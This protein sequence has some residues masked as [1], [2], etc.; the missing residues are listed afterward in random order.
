MNKVKKKSHAKEYAWGYVMIAPLVI[1]LSVFYFYPVFKV[2]FDSFHDVGAF[3]KSKWC[4]L[5]N[6]Q[7]MFQDPVMWQAL[8]NTIKYVLIIVPFTIIIALILASFLNMGIKGRSFFRVV[9]FIPAITMG[10]AVAMIW[11]WMYNGDYGIINY[12]L[13]LFG[14]ESI[15]FLSNS[16]TALVSI[17][18]VSIWSTVGYNMIILLAG[19][20]GISKSYYEAAAIDGAN[21]IKQ[22]LNITLPLVTPTLFFVMITTL[23]S[24]FQ[25]FDTIYMMVDKTS[26]AMEST[27]SMV[28][29]FY[30]NAFEYSKKGYASALAV[31]LFAIIMVI[32]AFQMKMQ[33]KWVNYE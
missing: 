11:R 25:T 16:K 5:E 26:L 14:I 8:G 10:A 15:R 13:N 24:T 31:F 29:Y 3:N 1:G 12:I 33:T 9:Y 20:Q 19:I 22:F 28:V 30:R 7:K 27:Q 21:G 32:T 23:I 4:G 18:V 2:F 6:Y 17:S